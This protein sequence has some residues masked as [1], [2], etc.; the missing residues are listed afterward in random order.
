M[1]TQRA[2]G[3]IKS[4]YILDNDWTQARER[5]AA[6]EWRA[7][8]VTVSHL[9]A[10]DVAA[11]WHCL[12]VG[13]GG[14]SIAEWL[15]RRVGKD[16]HVVATDINTRFLEALDFE[17]LTVRQHDIVSDDLEQGVFDL[18]HARAVLMHLPQ[19][20]VALARMM[21]ALKPGG[22]LVVE[23]GDF[24]S[25]TPDPRAGKE[26]SDLWEKAARARAALGA[27]DP[28]YARRLYWDVR[29]LGMVD[30]DAE[31]RVF[32]GRGATALADFY[33]L[34]FAQLRD[35]YIATGELTAEETDRYIALFSDPDIVWME[36]VAMTVWGRRPPSLADAQDPR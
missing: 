9:E 22:L 15:C 36:L 29:A 25:F 17:N 5:L 8:P 23:E 26:T 21:S 7:D 13:G 11:G 16:G 18:V 24:I 31:G 30:V 6:L 33:R 20:E 14:G 35:R 1:T 4:E 28:Y 19:R 34:S 3:G 12:E 2:S 27:T 32:M 10:R